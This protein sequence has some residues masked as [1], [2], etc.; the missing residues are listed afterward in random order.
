MQTSRVCACCCFSIANHIL[1]LEKNEIS[2]LWYKF[3]ISFEHTQQIFW[4]SIYIFFFH[5]KFLIKLALIRSLISLVLQNRIH[6][7]KNSVWFV[8]SAKIR[9]FY[10]WFSNRYECHRNCF[11]KRQYL[12]WIVSIFDIVQWRYLLNIYYLDRHMDL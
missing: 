5:T 12:V 6:T 10:F 4:Q 2:C 8:S 9:K 3:E 1:S 7:S 11:F